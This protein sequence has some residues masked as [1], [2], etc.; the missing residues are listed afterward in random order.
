M[1]PIK[2]NQKFIYLYGLLINL[3][4]QAPFSALIRR[5]LALL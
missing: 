1:S 4:C 5:C 3:Q 2:T